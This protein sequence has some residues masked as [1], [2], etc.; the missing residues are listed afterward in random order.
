MN[1]WLYGVF[2]I[3]V[4]VVLFTAVVWKETRLNRI[5]R[6]ICKY[7]GFYGLIE[8][9][10]FSYAGKEF[11]VVTKRSRYCNNLES[12][13]VY[14]NNNLVLTIEAISIYSNSYKIF[15]TP[16]NVNEEQLI[17]VLKECYKSH[18]FTQFN[19]HHTEETNLY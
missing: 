3:F 7:T 10:K 8:P 12:Y 2:F 19:K 9:E 18:I 11:V 6:K 1:Y 13:N 4:F 16:N 17:K 14:I 15:V 5:C